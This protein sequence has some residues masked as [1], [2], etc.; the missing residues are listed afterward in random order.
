MRAFI[1][2]VLALGACA[3]KKVDRFP[4]PENTAPV[5]A[6]QPQQQGTDPT[7]LAAPT[8]CVADRVGTLM[9]G[10]D[11]RT[12]CTGGD[13]DPCTAACEQGNAAACF[14]RATAIQSQREADAVALF[15][16]SCELGHALG[17]TNYAASTWVRN[18]DAVVNDC[19]RRIFEKACAVKE[20]FACG[21]IGRMMIALAK[22]A[23]EVER[24]RA[25]LEKTCSMLAGPS[26]KMLANHLQGAG[27]GAA[28]PAK[29]K[30]LLARAC[31]GGDPSA[32]RDI[33]Q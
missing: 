33:G 28:D 14:Y 17:C 12:D 16:R 7:E 5:P 6:V 31:E 11:E 23:A 27:S 26:C 2:V 24:G 10:G 32:C 25:Y 22:D 19:V 4:P 3:C 13:D 9:L 15:G 21:M 18:D 1:F 30:A 8:G 29:I 20:G